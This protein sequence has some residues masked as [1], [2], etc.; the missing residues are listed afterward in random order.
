M[1]APTILVQTIDEL[2]AE[3]STAEAALEEYLRAGVHNQ[4]MQKKLVEGL[5]SATLEYWAAA[6][7][8][9]SRA[10]NV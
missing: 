2:W 5:F 10:R 3:M 9:I 8:F 6:K 1:A 4:N 7:L